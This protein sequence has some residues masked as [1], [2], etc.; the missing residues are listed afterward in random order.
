MTPDIIL[1]ILDSDVIRFH[2]HRDRDLRG[3]IGTQQHQWLAASFYYCLCP[4]PNLQTAW[5]ILWHDVDEAYTCDVPGPLKQARPDLALIMAELSAITSEELSIPVLDDEREAM[6]CKLCDRLA[7]YY[8]VAQVAPWQLDED[9]WQEARAE[10]D[11]L[12]QRLRVWPA[13]E[14]IMGAMA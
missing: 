2:A 5:A 12:A 13:V 10:I 3:S 8:H 1:A 14:G 6:W 4:K 9:D 11:G 7:D